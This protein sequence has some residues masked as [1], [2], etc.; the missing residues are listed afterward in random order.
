MQSDTLP[1][2]LEMTLS[3]G[4]KNYTA[5]DIKSMRSRLQLSQDDFADIFFATKSTV[6]KWENGKRTPS[7]SS[8]RLLQLVEI[9]ANDKKQNINHRIRQSYK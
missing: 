4:F 6:T 7:C 1:P 2:F 3:K 5:E 9:V 8:M